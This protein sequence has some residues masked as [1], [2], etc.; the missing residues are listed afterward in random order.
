MDHQ[1]N[2]KRTTIQRDVNFYQTKIS[3]IFR[4]NNHTYYVVITVKKM[5]Q[6]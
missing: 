1:I 4:K 5:Q 6:Y 3:K 2:V